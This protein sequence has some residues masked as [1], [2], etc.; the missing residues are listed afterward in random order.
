LELHELGSGIQDA[1]DLGSGEGF[2]TQLVEVQ[3]RNAY[4]QVLNCSPLTSR[5]LGQ[6]SCHLEKL[7]EGAFH[8]ALVGEAIMS[9][10]RGTLIGLQ[11]P[12]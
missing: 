4:V 12:H 7:L 11:H 6:S 8:I 9:E 5:G 10:V 1:L 2:D 3:R